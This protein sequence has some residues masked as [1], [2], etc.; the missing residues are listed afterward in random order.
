VA[1]AARSPT[2]G[3]MPAGPPGDPLAPDQQR[4]ALDL[5]AGGPGAPGDAVEIAAG[6][7]HVPRWLDPAAQRDLVEACRAWA[8]PPAGL[9]RPHM[10]DGSPLGVRSVCLGWHWYPY[11][12]SR[13]CDDHDGAPVKPFPAVL[14]RLGAEACAATGF[15]PV[16]FDAA[17]VNHYPPGARLGQHQDRAEG[18]RARAAGS[19]VV[20]ISLGDSCVFRLGNVRDRGRPYHDVV[21]A[22]GDL[23]VF[24]GPARMSYHGVPRIRTGS[25][26][27]A[28]GLGGRLSV[29]LRQ[30]GLGPP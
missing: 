19:P 1:R 23:L 11:R 17:I 24:G 4:L 20:T 30:S 26:P 12:Y 9:R 2:P 6:A 22:S 21:L 16:A 7:V 28:L 10:P 18:E 14:S 3:P 25:G 27:P 29:T 5:D 13:T 8:A 15:P